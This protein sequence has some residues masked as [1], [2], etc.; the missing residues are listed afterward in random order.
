MHTQHYANGQST[1]MSSA[2]FRT[3]EPASKNVDDVQETA[4]P[5][6]VL[7]EYNL[8]VTLFTNPLLFVRQIED[9]R[10][11]YAPDCAGM[12]VLLPGHYARLL[13]GLYR[14]RGPWR[15]RSPLRVNETG[16]S[17][18]GNY[19]PGIPGLSHVV[20]TASSRGFAPSHI[21]GPRNG[22][23]RLAASDKPLQPSVRLLFRAS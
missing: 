8:G 17:Y 15:G 11:V 21:A 12:P 19:V 6:R 18:R 3:K 1:V 5:P 10:L 13:R 23:Q 9:R 16:S 22:A 20:A 2:A 7:F 14:R 4:I